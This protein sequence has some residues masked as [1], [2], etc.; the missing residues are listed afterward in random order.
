MIYAILT[1]LAITT[2]A[3]IVLIV[4][5]VRLCLRHSWLRATFVGVSGLILVVVPA[6]VLLLPA[7][8]T[9]RGG[10]PT[11]RCMS[12]LS[13]IGK[14]RA[15]YS[16]DHNESLPASFLSLTNY[17]DNPR[18]FVCPLSHNKPG[19]MET[20]N[21]W[22]DYILVTNLAAGS[23]PDLVLA[24]CKPEN[25]ADRNGVNVLFVDCSVIWVQTK[26]FRTIP[27][28]MVKHSRV[29][30]KPQQEH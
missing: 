21:E 16:C 20:V 2:V 9:P 1:A 5:T 14:A 23:D 30:R 25:H 10:S 28:D 26:D 12:N 19:P 15:L 6:V 29:S 18:L 27:C 7:C 17:V 22:T 8:A 3:G 13:Q 4:I 24:Y 11:T